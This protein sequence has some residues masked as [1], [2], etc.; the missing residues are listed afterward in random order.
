MACQVVLIHS[1]SNWY[2]SQYLRNSKLE[3][4]LSSIVV[5]L[6]GLIHSK[7]QAFDF[8]AHFLSI[9]SIFS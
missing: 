5:Q 6:N 3:I 4:G 9:F 1:K 8:L 2:F 7:T